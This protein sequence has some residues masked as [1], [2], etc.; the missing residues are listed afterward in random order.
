MTPRLAGLGA[1]G[2]VALGL[3]TDGAP[4]WKPLPFVF[5]LPYAVFGNAQVWLW[6]VTSVAGSL[7]GVVF[8]ARIAF[9]LTGPSP[10]RAYAPYVAA[11]VAGLGVL[12][13]DGYS[14]LVLIASSDPLIVTL[15]LAAIDCHRAAV[16]RWPS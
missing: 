12:G 3:N 13:L 5:T 16:P 2:A 8:A 1:P 10:G 9:R 15:C 6:M 11:A 14:H 4:S 7:A